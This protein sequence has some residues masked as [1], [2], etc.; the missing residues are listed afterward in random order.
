MINMHSASYNNNKILSRCMDLSTSL[1]Y[2]LYYIIIY[3]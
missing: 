3:I 1:N 2:I